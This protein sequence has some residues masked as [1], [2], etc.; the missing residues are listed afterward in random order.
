MPKNARRW[1]APVCVTAGLFAGGLC[2][3]LAA[4]DSGESGVGQL[5]ALDN[6]D[7]NGDWDVDLSDTIYLLGSLYS[8]GR[9]PVPLALCVGAE[10]EIRNGDTNGDGQIDVSD[11][12]SLL[13]WLFSN[14]R[15]P[16][17]ACSSA[18]VLGEG[19]GAQTK[20]SIPRIAPVNSRPYGKTY[21]E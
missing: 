15:P 8:G 14:G 4:L 3:R 20:N 21:A 7:V 17:D 11:A 2:A 12:I 5:Y 19:E 10:R 13:A 9:A 6:G 1:T 18:L 16:V